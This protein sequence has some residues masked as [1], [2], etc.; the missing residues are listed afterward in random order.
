MP[1]DELFRKNRFL[2]QEQAGLLKPAFQ[3]DILDAETGDTLLECRED[4]MG[5]WTRLVRF[6]HYRRTTPFDLRVRTTTGE[7]VM[8]VTRGIP[9]VVSR[10]QVFDDA[11][12]L[13]GVFRQRSFSF[14]GAFDVLD[15]TDQPVCSLKGKRGGTDFRFVTPEN[16]ELARITK[17]WAGLSKELFTS[18]D[19][20]ALEID[21][22]VPPDDVLRR[23][24][25][26]SAICIGMVLKIELP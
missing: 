6:S 13:I 5:R 17:Q 9:I 12:A 25:L 14:G 4:R 24:L 2:V 11:N 20:Y 23:L 8:R 1:L 21:P 3:S 15:A 22:A 18:A 19:H 10:V 16:V 7:P 26:A